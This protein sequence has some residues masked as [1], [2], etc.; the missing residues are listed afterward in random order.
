MRMP[1]IARAFPIQFDRLRSLM[2][3]VLAAAVFWTV[4]RPGPALAFPCSPPKSAAKVSL[5]LEPGEP[6]YVYDLDTAGIRKVVG[7]IQGYV[8]G[9]WHLPL[10]LTVAGLGLGFA[11]EFF[12]RKAQGVGYCVALAEAKV[13]VGYRDLR[14]YISSNYGE[15]S[16]EF[17]AILAHEQAHLQVNRGVLEDYKAKFRALLGRM[18]RGKKVIFVHRKTAARSAYILHLRRQFKPLVAEMRAVLARNNGAIDTKENYQK[19]LAQCDNWFEGD[20]AAAGPKTGPRQ[21]GPD[22]PVAAD[23]AALSSGFKIIHAPPA[24][25]E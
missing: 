15:G 8:A 14:V 7:D 12:V 1:G 11:T 24:N 4:T 19:V 23:R 10:G 13:T 22:D 2:V 25:P 18:R 3:V 17:D 21:A 20:L 16:C 6:R 5:R 9:P